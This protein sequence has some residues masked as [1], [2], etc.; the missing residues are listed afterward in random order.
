M[1]IMH[2]IDVYPAAYYIDITDDGVKDLIVTT[3]TENNSANFESCWFYENNGQ[4]KS[5]KNISTVCKR[6]TYWE[7]EKLIICI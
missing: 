5:W 7:A 4:N 2:S 6:S 3:N 1:L